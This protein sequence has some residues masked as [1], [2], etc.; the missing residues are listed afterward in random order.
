VYIQSSVGRLGVDNTLTQV[1]FVQTPLCTSIWCMQQGCWL[2]VVFDV[3][4][5]LMHMRSPVEG[6]R[7]GALT[8]HAADHVLDLSWECVCVCAAAQSL[9]LNPVAVNMSAQSV[10]HPQTCARCPFDQQYLHGTSI[11]GFWSDSWVPQM[12]TGRPE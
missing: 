6:K 7:V 12:R 4:L 9:L 1:E 11:T 2:C 3:A 8:P 10:P 5:Q